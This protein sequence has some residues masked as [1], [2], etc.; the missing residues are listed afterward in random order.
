MTRLPF[1]SPDSSIRS[2]LLAEIRQRR[3]EAWRRLVH[4]YGPLVY[5]WC[6]RAGVPPH[7][8]EDIGQEVFRAIAAGLG[9]FSRDKSG[10][11]FV[12]WM[13]QITRFKIADYF[14]ESANSPAVCGG[15]TFL[16]V[17]HDLPDKALE[18]T[19]ASQDQ[20]LDEERAI[21]VA[22]AMQ[23]LKGCFRENTWRAFWE[24]A[25]EHRETSDVAAELQITQMAV[26]KAKS[27]VLRRLRQ[28]LDSQP[29][30]SC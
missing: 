25:V 26:R 8:A 17:I 7:S 15:S 28:E 21:I 1:L 11:T 12:G 18:T 23:I 9:R 4:L 10:Q 13:R 3:P 2:S 14:R 20:V 5:H 27:R 6:R 30:L 29:P 24:T 22:R 19:A 16:N